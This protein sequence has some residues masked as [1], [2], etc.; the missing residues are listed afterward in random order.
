MATK[1]TAARRRRALDAGHALPGDPP[2]YPI[3][4]CDDVRNAV[5][6]LGRSDEEDRGEIRA[7]ITRRA[8]E[9]GC[10]E[11]LPDDWRIRG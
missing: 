11:D 4:D 6:D 2:R 1:W 8:I 9:L 10:T 5:G 7:F 3:S